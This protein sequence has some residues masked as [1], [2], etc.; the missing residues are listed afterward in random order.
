MWQ[1]QLNPSKSFRNYG[2][3]ILWGDSEIEFGGFEKFGAVQR[4][5]C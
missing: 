3:D 2:D 5:G 1:L 4:T